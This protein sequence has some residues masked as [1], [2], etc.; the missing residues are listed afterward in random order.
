VACSEPGW[1]AIDAARLPRS[2]TQQSVL[3]NACAA[4]PVV[5]L[6]RYLGQAYDT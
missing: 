5:D 3:T 6:L 4:H 1:M 2:S